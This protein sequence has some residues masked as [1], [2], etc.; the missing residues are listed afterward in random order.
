[1][2]ERDWLAE[3]L[4]G[5]DVFSCNSLAVINP[6]MPGPRHFRYTNGAT[7]RKTTRRLRPKRW[8]KLKGRQ[9]KDGEFT[10]DGIIGSVAVTN[11]EL[12]NCLAQGVDRVSG[13]ATVTVSP[14]S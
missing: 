9:S 1:M 2:D 6:I 12:A 13:V 7:R 10:G 11:T 14:S 4:P 5:H 3:R 8:S